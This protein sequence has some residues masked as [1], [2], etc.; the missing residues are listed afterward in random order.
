MRECVHMWGVCD[1]ASVAVHR[2]EGPNI[3]IFEI[4]CQASICEITPTL[5]TQ[6]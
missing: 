4:T 5:Y 6:H 1:K 3:S 2:G